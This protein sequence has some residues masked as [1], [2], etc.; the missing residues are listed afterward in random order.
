[1]K[2]TITAT[3]RPTKTLATA[4]PLKQEVGNSECNDIK[5]V[6]WYAAMLCQLGIHR[7]EWKYQKER[8]CNQWQICEWCGK[9]INLQCCHIFSRRFLVTRWDHNN[10]LCLCAGCHRKGHDKPPEFVEFI[11]DY[12]GT[13]KYNA[14]RR[15]AKTSI[16]KVNL[17]EVCEKYSNLLKEQCL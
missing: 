7:G 3:G 14:L 4:E 8:D 5:K 13:R 10:A 2:G 16:K 11:K 6:P 9:T 15:K 12:L 17:E 1:M